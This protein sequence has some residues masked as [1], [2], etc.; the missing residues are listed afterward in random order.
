[1]LTAIQR[2]MQRSKSNSALHMQ[3][4]RTKLN[5]VSVTIEG[6]DGVQLVKRSVAW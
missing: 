4:I 5:M 1:M 2:T 3:I 6:A